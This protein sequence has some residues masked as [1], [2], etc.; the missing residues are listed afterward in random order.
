VAIRAARSAVTGKSSTDV[1]GSI[2]QS[3]LSLIAGVVVG[4][5]ATAVAILSDTAR[6]LNASTHL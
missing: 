2:W 4:L 1:I 5:V 3:D 6:R